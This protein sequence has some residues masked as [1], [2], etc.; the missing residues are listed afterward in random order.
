MLFSQL[1][2]KADLKFKSEDPGQRRHA[3]WMETIMWYLD[4]S[5]PVSFT[6]ASTNIVEF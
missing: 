4:P 5:I 6:F 2:R 3:T 1:E